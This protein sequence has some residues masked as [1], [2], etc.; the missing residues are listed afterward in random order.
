MPPNVLPRVSCHGPG[1]G[2]APLLVGGV[3]ELM[4]LRYSSVNHS[5]SPPSLMKDDLSLQL[6][7]MV[8]LFNAPK[9][10][11]QGD[12]N[13]RYVTVFFLLV[14]QRTAKNSL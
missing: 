14:S 12:K 9:R 8:L 5:R 11:V 4:R 13:I 10:K 7:F 6:V 2:P 1:V 3:K